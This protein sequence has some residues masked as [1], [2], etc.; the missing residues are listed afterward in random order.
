VFGRAGRRVGDGQQRD[1]AAFVAGAQ[2]AE[3]DVLRMLVGEGAQQRHQLVVAVEAAV[4]D[5]SQ[6]D[7]GHEDDA[8]TARQQRASA[9]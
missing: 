6:V 7:G 4:V 9:R 3:R 5:G 2:R 1:R 8:E